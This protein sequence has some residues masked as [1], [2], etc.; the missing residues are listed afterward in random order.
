VIAASLKTFLISGQLGPIAI[1]L[2]RAKIA[3]LVGTPD[4]VSISRQ[5]NW[6]HAPR[7]WKYG[8]VELHFAVDTDQVALIH[9]DSFEILSGG[10]AIDLDPWLL[11]RT[12]SLDEL[13]TGL[14]S[15]GIGFQMIQNSQDP[16][17]IVR[18]NVGVGVELLYVQQQID[19]G[20]AAGLN[21]ISY[22]GSRAR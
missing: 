6:Q 3:H 21:A 22:G 19:Y 16:P 14:L 20:P 15:E 10:T 11:Q 7:I 17:E 13:Q 9:M 8:D 2:P 4:S 12:I 5:T 1:S 18:L